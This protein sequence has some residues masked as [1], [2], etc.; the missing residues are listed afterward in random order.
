MCK[1]KYHQLVEHIL[2]QNEYFPV[3]DRAPIL[4][5]IFDLYFENE[6]LNKKLDVDGEYGIKYSIL[7]SDSKH[8]DDYTIYFS[9]EKRR[10]VVFDD[11]KDNNY[12]DNTFGETVTYPPPAPNLRKMSKIIKHNSVIYQE[13]K[14]K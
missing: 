4:K 1:T 14:D 6:E 12:W 3:E 5:I 11:W 8:Y 9:S 13:I 2:N 7:P 10:D